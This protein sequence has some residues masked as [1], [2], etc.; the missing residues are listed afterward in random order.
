MV[1]RLHV[2]L[3]LGIALT[4]WVVALIVRGVPVTPELLVPYGIAVS[5]T[6]LL[7]TGFNHWC[8]RF[9]IFKGWLVQ[10]PWVQGT[11]RVEL[12]SSWIDPATGR[13]IDPI[14][15][16]MTIRQTFSSLTVRLHTRESSSTSI[17]SSIL[18]SEDGLFRLAISYQNEPRADLRGV[19]SEIH[20]GAM[21]LDVH[22]DPP[23]SLSGHYWTDRQTTG[24][25]QVTSRKDKLVSNFADAEALFAEAN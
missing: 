11:W 9:T 12:Q 8:W 25:L 24:T 1:T 6:T 2:A 19:R 22:G 16:F 13:Q 17:A 3:I 7:C 18:R 21:N 10:R 20:Y 23:T 4:V 5:A 15:C 14:H